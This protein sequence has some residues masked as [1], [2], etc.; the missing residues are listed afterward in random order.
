MVICPRILTLA[1]LGMVAKSLIHFPPF[2]ANQNKSDCMKKSRIYSQVE[3]L[4]EN[5]LGGRGSFLII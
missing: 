3:F 2:S 4:E 1:D 5:I